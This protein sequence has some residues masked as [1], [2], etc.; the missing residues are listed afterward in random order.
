MCANFL[1]LYIHKKIPINKLLMPFQQWKPLPPTPPPAAAAVPQPPHTCILSCPSLSMLSYLF[2]PKDT[3]ELPCNKILAHP[4]MSSSEA[5]LCRL[6][7][8]LAHHGHSG[9]SIF[10]T[11]ITH[12]I[13]EHEPCALPSKC[14]IQMCNYS[15]LPSGYRYK[16]YVLG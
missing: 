3:W 11:P 10:C 12:G 1:V 6:L 5:N 15:L 8:N 4:S 7:Y 16:Q 14:E 9:L 13:W 2:L